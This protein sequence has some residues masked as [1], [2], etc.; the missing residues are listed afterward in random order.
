MDSKNYINPLTSV[1]PNNGESCNG[2]FTFGCD[3]TI[4]LKDG[5][6]WRFHHCGYSRQPHANDGYYYRVKA[7]GADDEKCGRWFTPDEI[8][9]ATRVNVH[10]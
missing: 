9:A 5:S 3:S 8:R 6:V 10:V 2:F 7:C 4:L 1:H